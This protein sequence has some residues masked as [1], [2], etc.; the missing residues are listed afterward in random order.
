M[1]SY[2]LPTVACTVNSTGISAPTFEEI[3]ASKIASYQ[4]IF[5]SDVLLTPDTQDYQ[6]IAIEAAAQNDSNMATIAA[7]NNF[8]PANSQGIGQDSTYKINGIRREAATN[9]TMPAT[10]VGVAGTQINFGVVQDSN[11]NLWN[12]P[13]SV[14]IPPSGAIN[15]TLTAQQPGSIAANAQTMTPYSQVLGW[16]STTSTAAATPGAPVETD[17]EFRQRQTISTALTSITPLQSIAAALAN[18]AGVV[19]SIVYEN[20]TDEY[21]TGDETPPLVDGQPPHSICA[22]V[23]QVGATN[24]AIAQTIEATKAPLAPA[25]ALRWTASPS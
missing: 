18:L 17:G 8:N 13:A 25:P 1:P 16:Q 11:G 21:G 9:S 7:Y 12:L 14:L 19:R 3:L 15:I 20:S 2:P 5:G 22:V 10:I 4:A 6:A 24:T 23:G